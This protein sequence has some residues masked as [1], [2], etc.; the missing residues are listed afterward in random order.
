[1]E[2]GNRTDGGGREAFMGVEAFP[3]ENLVAIEEIEEAS[4][5]T[6]LLLYLLIEI[7]ILH[8]P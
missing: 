6:H 4:H 5:A 2:K 7:L 1:M 8:H 3:G